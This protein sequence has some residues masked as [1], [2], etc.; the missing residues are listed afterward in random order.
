[1]ELLKSTQQRARVFWAIVAR[2][3]ITRYGRNNIG[4][5]W[6]LLEP[7]LFSLA[8]VVLWSLLKAPT[9]PGMSVAG[10]ALTGYAAVLL[11]RY[12]TNRCTNALQTNWALLYHRVVQPLDIYAARIFVEVTAATGGC[13]VLAIGLVS[14]GQMQAPI[15]PF[16]V[17]IAW[18][19]LILFA[20]G[21]A[22]TVGGL[23]VRSES[24]ERVWHMLAYL[25][26]PV[27]GP[28][29]MVEWLPDTAREVVLV[30]PMVHGVE[31]L[32]GAWFGEAVAVYGNPMYLMAASL[33]LVVVGL[34]L[35]NQNGRRVEAPA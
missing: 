30:L 17:A 23:S 19:L 12:P 18:Y 27:S 22:L 32:R 15:D 33:V 21:L 6:V 5:L 35:V 9:N 34:A 11:W 8:I 3:M 1:V 26:F 4:F 29:F 2:E 24:F 31:M 16:G 28:A 20:I 25:L 10:F 14:I 7:L 13:L